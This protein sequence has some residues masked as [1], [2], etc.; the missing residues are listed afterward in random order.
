MSTGSARVAFI[1][2]VIVLIWGS[3]WTAIRFQLGVE[4]PGWSIAWRFSIAALAMAVYGRATG[5]S[6]KLDRADLPLLLAIAVSQFSLNFLFIYNAERFI[7]S[8]LVAM[9]FALLIVPNALL[10]SLFL[11]QR[12]GPAFLFGTLLAMAGMALLFRHEVA[13]AVTGGGRSVLLGIALALLGTLSASVGNLL[14][15][16]QRAAHLQAPQLLF[17]SM[18][19]G[20]LFNMAV[21][22]AMSGPPAI[23]PRPE[24]WA[25]TLWLGIAGSAVTF[26]LYLEVMRSIG[27]ARAAYSSVLVPIV[28]MLFS[29]LFEG[30]RW[31]GIA[32][33]GALLAAIG[34]VVALRGRAAAR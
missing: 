3:T 2:A 16:S 6:L 32:V 13:A 1:F 26:P 19:L 24:Y 23:D 27:P 22:L 33:A 28:A 30:Y 14:Q 29:T 10:G 12:V 17:W 21:G 18:A 9:I 8:G 4:A 34:L 11:K 31:S 20:A 5:V 15:A 25:A 7:T